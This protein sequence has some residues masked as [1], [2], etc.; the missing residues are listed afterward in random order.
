M[1][2]D[3]VKVLV[4]RSVKVWKINQWKTKK[5]WSA[6]CHSSDSERDWCCCCCCYCCLSCTNAPALFR[7]KEVERKKKK[8]EGGEKKKRKRSWR[9]FVTWLG[10]QTDLSFRLHGGLLRGREVHYSSLIRARRANETG[11]KVPTKDETRKDMDGGMDVKREDT[12]LTRSWSI[13]G[14]NPRFCQITIDLN[15]CLHRITFLTL[16]PTFLQNYLKLIYSV[17]LLI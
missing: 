2:V 12:S 4:C 5:R 8:E 13:D 10:R 9:R 7:N 16:S 17:F 3:V 6:G 1:L 11:G 14:G 15:I